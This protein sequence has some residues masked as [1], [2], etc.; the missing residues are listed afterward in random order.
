MLIHCGSPDIWNLL[1]Q[2]L[3]DDEMLPGWSVLVSSSESL[4]G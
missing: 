2:D 4:E 3:E 1:Q